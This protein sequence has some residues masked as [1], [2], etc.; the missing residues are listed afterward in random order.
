MSPL[1]SSVAPTLSHHISKIKHLI[2]NR[3]TKVA[4][5][6]VFYGIP[7]SYQPYCAQQALRLLPREHAFGDFCR[8]SKFASQM[9]EK[10]ESEVD[11][12]FFDPIL[13]NIDIVLQC[14]V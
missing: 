2:K 9:G 13:G 1:F 6:L 5:L 10:I 4:D 7:V 8:S 12:N 14:Y 11:D 3:Y